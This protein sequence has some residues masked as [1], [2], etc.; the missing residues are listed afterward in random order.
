ASLLLN[1][2]VLVTGGY[3]AGTTMLTNAL[4]SSELWDP[5]T[6]QWTVTGNMANPHANQTATVLLNGTVLIAGGEAFGDGFLGKGPTGPAEFYTPSTGAW[7]SLEAMSTA[8]QYAAAGVT[9]SRG[10]VLVAGGNSGGCCTGLATA[11]LFEPAAEQC[12]TGCTPQPP[13]WWYVQDM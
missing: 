8:R 12:L 6:G 3:T 9:S 4:T 5:V 1:G 10:Q 11:E 7:A 2:Q 13:T